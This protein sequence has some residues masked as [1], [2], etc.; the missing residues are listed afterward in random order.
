[1]QSAFICQAR[2]V[3][4]AEPESL[5]HTLATHPHWSRKRS[6]RDLCQRWQWR[7]VQGPLQVLAARSLW[8]KLEARALLILPPLRQQYHTGRWEL[9]SPTLEL[10]ARPVPLEQPLAKLQPLRWSLPLARSPEAGRFHGY[11]RQYHYLGLRVAG[12]N[13]KYLV[14]ARVGRLVACLLFA[15]AAS[16]SGARVRF[17]GCAAGQRARGLSR[18][19]NNTPFLILPWV[20]VACLASQLLA[21]TARR[22]SANWQQKYRHPVSWSKPLSSQIGLRAPLI[23]PPTARALAKPKGPAVS[24]PIPASAPPR[25]K[26]SRFIPCIGTFASACKPQVRPHPCRSSGHQPQRYAQPAGDRARPPNQSAG[27]AAAPVANTT[28]AGRRSTTGDLS[29]QWPAPASGPV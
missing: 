13:L 11:L 9:R 22:L 28:P 21:R 17:V 4:A 8:L 5:R 23:R 6:P 20:K 27:M 29:A 19:V 12:E 15:A 16:Q 2:R 1:M 10:L 7:T 24:G 14:Q 25:L 3:S 26:P 18:V